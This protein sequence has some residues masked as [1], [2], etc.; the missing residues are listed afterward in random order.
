MMKKPFRQAGERDEVSAPTREFQHNGDVEA[1]AESATGS[2]AGRGGIFTNTMH[3][4]G[5]RCDGESDG[6]SR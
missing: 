6:G 5:P 1:A 2:R 4:P 3:D